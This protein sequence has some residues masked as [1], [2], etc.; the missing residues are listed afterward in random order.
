MA[1]VLD[2]LS[3]VRTPRV[4]PP[5]KWAGGK[6]WL[7]PQLKELWAS[8]EDRRLVEPLCGGLA[9]VLGLMP[10]RALLNDISPHLINFYRHLKRGLHATLPMSK[11][12][13]AYY[14]YRERFNRLVAEGNT[15]TEEAAQL[16]YYL[17]R[18]CYNGLCRFNRRGEFNVP[19]GRYKAIGYATTEDFWTYK[20]IFSEWEFSA[21][22]FEQIQLTPEDFVYADPPYDVEFTQYAREGFGWKDQERLA[23]WLAAHSGPVV[24]SNQYT[25]RIERLYEKYGFTLRFRKLIAPRMISCNG[26]RSPA[27]EVLA[28][29]GF[30]PVPLRDTRT[31]FVLEEMVLPTLRQGG[32][33]FRT[34]VDVGTRPGG[35]RHLVD[36]L[37]RDP[38]GR[39]FLLSV[40]WQQTSGTAEQ[41]VPFE[42]ICLADAMNAQ[43]GRYERAY[44]VLGG[45]GWKLRDYFI[46]G[47]LSE[48]L[49][50]A[51]RV[52]IISLEDFVARAN[53]TQL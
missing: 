22:D 31:G 20:D 10:R 12:S 48:H 36:V 3:A 23:E 4:R 39:E 45:K 29:K 15:D 17:N 18:T 6:R 32:Y 44:L 41:K 19:F 28:I 30:K 27:M 5:L 1:A 9:V 50:H 7:V 40:K 11:D 42:V 16:F 53:K 25:R 47:A 8:H 35:A 51:N 46:S 13:E 14:A 43:A 38:A 26:N 2:G 37:A 24:L 21:G 33:T 52:S 34:Q 49:I